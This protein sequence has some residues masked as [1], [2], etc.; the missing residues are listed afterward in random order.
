MSMGKRRINIMK[1]GKTE[2]K[3]ANTIYLR[4]PKKKQEYI[5]SKDWQF[6]S[7]NNNNWRNKISP[8]RRVNALGNS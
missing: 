7:D 6:Q 1:G 5:G 8:Y 2:R 4:T 3:N